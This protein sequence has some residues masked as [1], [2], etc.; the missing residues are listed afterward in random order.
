M[1]AGVSM[2]PRAV[3]SRPRR[4]A[5]SSARS[6]KRITPPVSPGG[7]GVS[8]GP[9]PGARDFGDESVPDPG[10]AS[11]DDEPH[12]DAPLDAAGARLGPADDRTDRRG[13]EPAAD[14]D[15]EHLPDRGE[16]VGPPD[17]AAP[18]GD[19]ERDDVVGHRAVLDPEGPLRRVA[20]GP[21]LEADRFSPRRHREERGGGDAPLVE[22]E[23][24]AGRQRRAPHTTDERHLA[25]EGGADGLRDD[26]HAHHGLFPYPRVR[27]RRQEERA[28]LGT[29]PAEVHASL[30]VHRFALHAA[31]PHPGPRIIP[32]RPVA[33]RARSTWHPRS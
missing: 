23:L 30:D 31:S 26:P 28:A 7:P 18:V 29:P 15:R 8:S 22:L 2:T 25:E 11:L 21:I 3:W 5:P 19:V 14:A 10:G 33:R 12:A 1:K 32:R 9:R 20:R 6:S 24:H 27:E 13:E 17:G 4:A 16:L